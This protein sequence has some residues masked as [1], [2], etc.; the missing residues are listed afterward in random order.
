MTREYEFINRVVEAYRKVSP[1]ALW[2]NIESTSH[3][4]EFIISCEAHPNKVK[5]ALGM[6]SVVIEKKYFSVVYFKSAI[7]YLWLR[8][9]LT[10]EQINKRDARLKEIAQA[11]ANYKKKD[12]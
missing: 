4:N 12:K 6:Q 7:K 10:P 2:A 3:S 1:P 5:V 9:E 11:K 8:M